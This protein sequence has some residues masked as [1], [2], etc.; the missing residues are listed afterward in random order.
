M[1]VALVHDW[2][3]GMRGGEKVLEALCELFPQVD[4]YTLVHI[5]GSVSPIIEDR[6]IFTSFIQHLPDIE[7]KY[8]YYLPLMPKAIEQFDLS[9]YELVVSSSHCVAKGVK[10]GEKTLHICY[11][12]TPMRYIWDMYDEYFGDAKIHIKTLMKILRKYLQ[13][14][15]IESSKRVSY[16]IANSKNVQERVRRCYNQ[17]AKIIYPPVDV[18]FFT[19]SNSDARGKLYYLIVSAF[20]P[21]K[22]IDLAIEAFNPL[23]YPLKIIGSGQEAKRLKDMAKENIEFLGWLSNKEL[24]KYYQNCKALIFP[25]EEDFGIVPVEAQACGT[26]VIAY[27][28]GGVT[29]TVIPIQNTEHRAQNSELRRKNPQLETL[30]LPPTGIFFYEQTPKALIEAVR[31]F[32][33]VEDKFDPYEIRKNAERFSIERFKR[34]FKDFVDERIKEFF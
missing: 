32:E 30:N 33:T 1:K 26:P 24:K 6:K 21:Y 16:F 15:D 22:R 17:D 14:W 31:R 9:K 7:R 12:H 28:K 13:R 18:D 29:E 23:R 8:R 19:P 27:G 11:C 10:A 5:K 2:L 4:L 25:T 34:E 3:T 20:A